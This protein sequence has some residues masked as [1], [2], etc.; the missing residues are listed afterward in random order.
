MYCITCGTKLGDD[1]AI[2]NCRTTHELEM[3]AVQPQPTWETCEIVLA[4][5][6]E[7][8]FS[9][10]VR[11]EVHIDTPRGVLDVARSPE[12]RIRT[13]SARIE[14]TSTEG[15]YVDDLVKRLVLDGWEPLPRGVDWFSFRFRRRVP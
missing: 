1:L 13:N 4:I 12:F 14:A 2:C 5:V 8:V 9:R 11:W 6:R 15:G 3:S 7:N 10:V